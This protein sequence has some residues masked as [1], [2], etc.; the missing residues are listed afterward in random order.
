MWHDAS[1]VGARELSPALQ[2]WVGVASEHESRRDGT[3]RRLCR[4]YGTP[5]LHAAYPA[6]KRWAK[7]FC[8]ASG[9]LSGSNLKH[10]EFHVS[11]PQGGRCAPEIEFAMRRFVTRATGFLRSNME[12]AG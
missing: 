7:L 5:I 3:N 10:G 6:L 8:P 12:A 11:L 9:T 2:R 4:A 1:A